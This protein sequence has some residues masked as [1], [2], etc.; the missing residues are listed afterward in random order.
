MSD[1][2]KSKN[3]KS[4]KGTRS[5]GDSEAPKLETEKR[6]SSRLT[7]KDIDEE[8]VSSS[9][10]KETSSSSQPV[11]A[12]A[13]TPKYDDI[14]ANTIKEGIQKLM[15]GEV[16]QEEIHRNVDFKEVRKNIT[17]DRISEVMRAVGDGEE[18]LKSMKSLEGEMSPETMNEA[19]KLL[20]SREGKQII[21][22]VQQIVPNNRKDINAAKER[23]KLETDIRRAGMVKR[24]PNDQCFTAVF[25]TAERKMKDVEI[26]EST[27]ED[28][29]LKMFKCPVQKS[30]LKKYEIGVLKDTEIYIHYIPST[31]LKHNR[32][33][34]KISGI[35]IHGPGLISAKNF[36]LNQKTLVNVMELFEIK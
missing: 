2:S 34:S 28:D 18:F 13:G 17:K 22:Q 25:I 30:R 35:K 36:Q 23:R 32:L 31:V 33:M 10:P 7:K 20:E 9:S 3:N 5:E 16:S 8:S 15:S 24:S 1:K 6:A 4:N 26:Y 11:E 14:G 21:K 29:I 19:Q 27:Y 12:T